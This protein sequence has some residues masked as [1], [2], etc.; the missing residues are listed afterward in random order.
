M[1]PQKNLTAICAS[2]C[3]LGGLG[4][5]TDPT[6]GS[7]PTNTDGAT[8]GDN[9]TGTGS[10]AV[11]NAQPV[12]PTAHPRIYLTPNRARLVASLHAKTAAATRFKT[13]VDAWVGGADIW[14]FETWTAALLGQLTGNT[15]YCTKAVANVDAQV[16]A[17]EAV[18]ANNQAPVV[19]GDSYLEIG[20]MI[21]DLALT[22]DWCFAE[23]SSSQRARWLK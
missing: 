19:A 16:S 10:G 5:V 6:N 17:A 18:I 11:S 8:S 23:T 2:L 12:Y 1:A 13:N 20:G 9:F 21:G 14:G 22:Y 4:C 15:A 7:D 3:L